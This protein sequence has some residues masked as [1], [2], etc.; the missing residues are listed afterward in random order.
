MT[1]ADI[2]RATLSAFARAL[3]L[4]ISFMTTIPGEARLK[5]HTPFSNADM[6]DIFLEKSARTGDAVLKFT[7]IVAYAAMQTGK[8][9]FMTW[10]SIKV[11][12]LICLCID[13]ARS[14]VLLFI[15]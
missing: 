2:G 3:G 12:V 11:C 5:D 15:L 9:F 10:I 14:D 13:I 8:T 4:I 1:L 7:I 6:N